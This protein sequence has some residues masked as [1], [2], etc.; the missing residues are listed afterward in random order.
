MKKT[1]LRVVLAFL[2]PFALGEAALRASGLEIVRDGQARASILLATQKSDWLTTSAAE[3]L[4]SV[5][6]GWTG[7][8]IRVIDWKSAR[9]S[10]PSGSVL[11]LAEAGA[12]LNL[13]A[14]TSRQPFDQAQLLGEGGFACQ[15]GEF[16]GRV[17]FFVVGRTN[18]G[19]FNG[20]QYVRDFLLD[21]PKENLQLD[22]RTVLRSPQSG[23]RPI[24]LLTIWGNEAEYTPA[25]WETCFDSFARDG[26]DRVYFW[27]SG[28]FPSKKYPQTYKVKD[29]TY[30]TTEKSRIGTVEDQQRLIRSARERGLMFY[31]GGALGG[32][33]G[34][35]FLTNQE[36]GTTKT[37][38]PGAGYEG[39]YSLC[40]SHPK[41]RNALIE[42]YTEMFD[43]L[44]E[45]DGVFIESADEWG[46]CAC[47]RCSR[48]V[49]EAGSTY[50]G[51]AQLSLLQEIAASIW[52]RHPKARFCYTIG[53]DEHRKDPAY[54]SV[55]RQM[56]D[57][58]F[59]WME[60]RNSWTF[61]SDYGKD[62][63]AAYFTP[64]AMRWQQ[65]YNKP[66][67]Q[68]VEDAARA[69][70]EG[71]YGLITAFEPGASGDFYRQIPYPTNVIPQ[72]VTHFVLREA[73][74][75]APL[76]VDQMLDRVQRRF[77]GVEAPKELGQALWDLREAMLAAAPQNSDAGK[78]KEILDRLSSIEQQAKQAEGKASPKTLKTI[79]LMQKAIDDTRRH[80]GPIS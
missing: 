47:E 29:D 45:A 70:A 31:I 77:F 9:A 16:D 43:A 41:S 24:Y 18:R 4:R 57:P 1:N 42:Y 10:L 63:P 64:R 54:Y 40:P 71:W 74:W 49:D 34:T 78:K 33:V 11:V 32:W 2:V 58:R 3:N 27:L 46:G 12:A 69:S 68:L 53:Y 22:A 30:D 25:D 80:L 72:I 14:R 52:T 66:L 51:Q 59:E 65:Y 26:F 37:R 17:A 56:R 39:K 62:L 61:P 55:I 36:P 38:A 15:P 35:R 6:Q 23:G 44:S 73:N 8:A 79:R 75:D 5:I 60:A 67:N 20:A 48:V 13:P 7:A 50:F 28:H 76:T 19:V 21:G